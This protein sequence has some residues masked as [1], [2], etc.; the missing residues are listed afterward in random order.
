MPFC[1]S[2]VEVASYPGDSAVTA[3]LARFGLD[4]AGVRAACLAFACSAPVT[5]GEG[6]QQRIAEQLERHLSDVLCR[7]GRLRPADVQYSPRLG[8]KADVA[9]RSESGTARLYCE[10]EFRPNVE[11]DLVKFQIGANAGTLGVA[12]LIVALDRNSINRAYTTMPE[13]RKYAK[14][15]A[16]LRPSYP[17]LLVGIDGTYR[18]DPV[19]AAV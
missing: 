2:R 15:I 11:K 4:V 12:L 5:V 7:Q 13:F 9:L 17:L 6:Y 18:P 8:E 19:A 16:E 1:I 10:I 14:V 3:A